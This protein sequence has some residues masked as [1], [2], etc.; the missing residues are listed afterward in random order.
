MTTSSQD[1]NQPAERI[2]GLDH[3]ILR[4][5]KTDSRKSYRTIAHELDTTTSTVIKHVKGLESRGIVR[6]YGA[7]LDYEKLGYDIIALVELTISKGKLIEVEREVAKIP[8]VFAVYDVTGT[9][10]AI[11]LARFKT[12]SALNSMIKSILKLENVERTNTHLILNVIKE[13]TALV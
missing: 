2:E 7:D 13:G 5:L 3:R 10:D 8:N 11:V 6:G 4:I 1:P 12:R 9:Y